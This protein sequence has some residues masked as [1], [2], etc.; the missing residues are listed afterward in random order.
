M[1]H[2]REDAPE[3]LAAWE[4]AGLDRTSMGSTLEMK[5]VLITAMR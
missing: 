4:D 5:V 2:A 3:R 1:H